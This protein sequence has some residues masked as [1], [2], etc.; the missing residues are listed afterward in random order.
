MRTVPQ[1]NMFVVGIPVKLLLGLL[2]LLITMPAFVGFSNT[3]F[4]E[5]YTNID[6]FFASF[7]AS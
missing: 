2:I 6:T 5:M 4:G 1:L 3:V 7:Y